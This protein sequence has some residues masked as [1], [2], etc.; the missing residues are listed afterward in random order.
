MYKKHLHF[1][2]QNLTQTLSYVARSISENCFFENKQD[3][4]T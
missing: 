4:E 2:F 1:R 3:I